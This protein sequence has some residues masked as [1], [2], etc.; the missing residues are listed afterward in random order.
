MHLKRAILNI[1]KSYSCTTNLDA[2]I[3]KHNQKRLKKKAKENKPWNSRTKIIGGKY[4]TKSIVYKSNV[5][6]KSKSMSYRL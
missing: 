1:K 4:L 2:E 5:T 3:S 6:Y